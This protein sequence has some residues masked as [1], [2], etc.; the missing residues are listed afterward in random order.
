ML[1]GLWFSAAG[2]A[3]WQV[4]E[5]LPA[6]TIPC[7]SLPCRVYTSRGQDLGEVDTGGMQNYT[8]ALSRDGRFAAAATFTSDV[9]AS[10][11]AGYWAAGAQPSWPG[12]CRGALMVCQSTGGS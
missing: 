11:G 12:Q 10:A 3:D 5:P 9:K 6:L 4:P 7:V 8:A 1:L 2:V